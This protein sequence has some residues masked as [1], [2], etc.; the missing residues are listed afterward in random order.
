[1][2]AQTLE[3]PPVHTNIYSKG[4]TTVMVILETVSVTLKHVYSILYRIAFK[5]FFL[6]QIN[7]RLN[8]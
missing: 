2:F 7:F 8:K 4:N 1:M 5:D 3:F 6:K